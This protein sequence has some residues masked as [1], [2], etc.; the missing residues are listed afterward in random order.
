M[1]LSSPNIPHLIDSNT[2]RPTGEKEETL[3]VEECDYRLDYINDNNQAFFGEDYL[4]LNSA[5]SRYN[6]Q[7]VSFVEISKVMSISK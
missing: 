4:N 7:D 6:R 1:S 5:Q 3:S 2:C